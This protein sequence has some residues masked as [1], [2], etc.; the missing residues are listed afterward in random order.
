MV[1]T[2]SEQVFSVEKRESNSQNRGTA[3]YIVASDREF[4]TRVLADCAEVP[5][6]YR[7]FATI[8]EL[9]KEL[10]KIEKLNVAVVL[11]VEKNGDDVDAPELRLFKLNYPQIFFIVLLGACE[12]R[13]ILRLQS[14]GVQNILLPPFSEVN[15]SREISTALP[16]IPH[17]KKHPDLPKR[18]QMR[19]NFLIPSDLSYV[20]GLNH[21]ISLM[22][23]EFGFPVSESRINIPLACDE[24]LTNAV[25]HGNGRD[26]NKKVNV[27]IY[28][29]HSRFK[30]RVADQGNGFDVADVENP[31]KGENLLRSSGRGIYMMRSIMDSVEFKDGGKVVEMEK[32][33][34]GASHLK[35]GNN[36]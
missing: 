16:N 33:N 25:L 30:I 29:S 4:L 24:A 26:P 27:Q 3:V 18:G 36:G 2:Y 13:N 12:Q 19:V 7:V 35:N 23:K 31:L 14:L 9:V 15:I 17:F 1:R 22:L 20:L 21:F 28:V 10:S 8:P 11:I 6:D 32:V 5:P 34:P